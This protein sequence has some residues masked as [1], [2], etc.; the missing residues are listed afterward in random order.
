MAKK[1]RRKSRSNSFHDSWNIVKTYKQLF[2]PNIIMFAFQLFLFVIFARFSGFW[3][4][5]V[6]GQPLTLKI[7]WWAISYVLIVMLVDNYFLTAKYG[8][9][10]H[11]VKNGKVDLNVAWKFAR[12]YY[13]TTLQIHVASWLIVI[14]PLSLLAALLFVVLPQHPIVALNLFVA[15]AITYM[16]YT[17]IRLLYV[18]PIMTFHTK[19]AYKTITEDFHFVKTHMHSTIIT[20][21]IVVGVGFLASIVQHNLDLAVEI[22]Q[23]P[24]L[25][26]GIIGTAIIVLVEMAVSVWEHVF[27]FM[28]YLQK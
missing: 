2:I 10:S 11:A 18:Y 28:R 9:I 22:M 14:V 20:W 12:T 16:V 3:S 25:F 6:T 4:W 17:G 15:I 1:K 24:L 26:I 13:W 23:G 5:L 7:I 19:G 8:M 21:L 27:I